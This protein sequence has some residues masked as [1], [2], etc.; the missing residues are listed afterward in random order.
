MNH[1]SDD[2]SLS[3][4]TPKPPDSSSATPTTVVVHLQVHGMMCQA[5]CGRTVRNALLQLE[6]V[7]DAQALFVEQRAYAVFAA[8]NNNQDQQGL[9]LLETSCCRQ[10][11]V[12]AVQAV[13]FDATI[14]VDNIHG[15]TVHL[16]VDG[17]MCQK[18]CGTTVANALQS[19]DGVVEAQAVFGE[20]R[21]YAVFQKHQSLQECQEQA[22]DMIECVG[23][24]AQVIDDIDAYLSSLEQKELSSSSLP[25]AAEE[26]TPATDLSE[27]TLVLQVGGMSCA[28]CTGRVERALQSAHGSVRHVS[29]ILATARAVVELDDYDSLSITEQ[30]QQQDAIAQACVAAVQKAGY[31]CELLQQRSLP[32][33]AAALERARVDELRSWRRLLLWATALTVPLLVLS[34]QDDF[35]ALN[36]W[37]QFVL[38]TVIQGY[39][40][41]RY[42]LAAYKGLTNGGVMGMDFLIVLG[43]TASY[44]YSVVLF[45]IWL[46]YGKVDMDPSFLTSG[47]LLTFVTL[48]KFLESYAKGKTASALQTLMELQPLFASRVVASAP[49][50]TEI[51]EQVDI[52]S[53]QIQEVELADIR[54][55]DYLR[56]LPGSRI[57][58]DG[59]L[60]AVSTSNTSSGLDK[61]P[62]QAFVDESALTGEPFPVPKAV[63]DDLYGSTV[64]QLSVLVM[65]VTATG[66]ETALS[67]IVKLMEDAQRHK[68]PIQAYADRVACVFA[69][70]VMALSLLTLVAW[71]V[72]NQNAASSQERFFLA[73][74]SAISVIV[75]ACPCALGL[76]TPTAVSCWACAFMHCRIDR[77]L[78]LT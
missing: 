9:Q 57:P 3:T 49:N 25:A 52:S 64:N 71:L 44:V 33:N 56:V 7:V 51:N 60:V 62:Q 69:P 15:T 38:G 37:L 6:G 19:I 73:F 74:M 27:N 78:L 77:I 36:L 23:F 47:M 59:T 21:A 5:N 31:Q 42:Y 43:T 61:I 8:T 20:K 63:G 24:E 58:T 10:R 45:G 55:G 32:H 28:V 67:K 18:N 30:Q 22:I 70:A 72:L 76:A 46:G 26:E 13:G 53:L 16:Q 54:V 66:G 41:R 34:K 35:S 17:M 65:K 40:G 29:V 75:V 11:A 1:G 2:D 14:V 50:D 48:G 68:A 12:E 4:T 39:I